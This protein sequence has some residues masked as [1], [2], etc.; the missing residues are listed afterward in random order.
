LFYELWESHKSFLDL[1]PSPA[2]S[3]YGWEL[4]LVDV[5]FNRVYWSARVDHYRSNSQILRGSQ[6]NDSTMF[7]VL[8][9]ERYWLWTVGNKKP[10]NITLNWNTEKKDLLDPNYKWIRWENDSI[11]AKGNT[12]I[13]IFIDTKTKTVNGREGTDC[14]NWWGKVVGGGGGLGS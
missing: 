3:Y 7:I 12:N 9:G 13:D 10:Q 4:K 2:T 6:W 14:V 8:T 5:R 1:A 11:F